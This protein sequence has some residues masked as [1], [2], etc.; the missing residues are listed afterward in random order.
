[1]IAELRTKNSEPG[2]E[3][4]TMN[5]NEEPGTRNEELVIT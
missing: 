5:K 1:M 4:R 2:T 3:N